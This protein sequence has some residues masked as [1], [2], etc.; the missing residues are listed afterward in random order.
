MF[1]LWVLFL[2]EFW[3]D[4]CLNVF[5]MCLGWCVRM[6]YFLVKVLDFWW[7]FVTSLKMKDIDEFLYF[8][9]W[10]NMYRWWRRWMKRSKL[11]VCDVRCLLRMLIIFILCWRVIRSTSIL[12]MSLRSTRWIT[13]LRR[14]WCK[15]RWRSFLRSDL[16]LVSFVGFLFVLFFKCCVLEEGNRREF[17]F[18]CLV[19]MIISGEI[20]FFCVWCV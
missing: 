11:S 8:Y 2:I 19:N 14:L 5:V 18:G 1:W 20:G 17:R 13:L 12:R 6:L 4:E 16:R 10:L 3:C 7:E 9:V 15:R